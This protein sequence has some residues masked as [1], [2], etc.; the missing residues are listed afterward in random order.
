GTFSSLT[1]FGL[2]AAFTANLSYTSTN[3]IL[4]LTA[5]LGQPSGPGGP[6][7]L[8]ATALSGNQQN[9]A[10]ALNSFFNNGRALPPALVSIFGLTGGNLAN[11]LTA[12]S[13]ET[14]TGSQQVASS[15]PTSSSR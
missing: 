8:G 2:P 12:L 5:T 9:V 1:T 10:N 14:A 13:G 4:N 7:A 11:A 3:A 6:G 15:S